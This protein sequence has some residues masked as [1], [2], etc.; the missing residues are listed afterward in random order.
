[1]YQ[2][3][4]TKEELKGRRE[5]LREGIGDATAIIVGAGETSRNEAFQQYHDFYYLC[6][7]ET[8]QSYLAIDGKTGETTLFLPEAALLS[9]D[10]DDPLICVDDPAYAIEVTGVDHVKS[11]AD[12]KEYLAGVGRLYTDFKD[13]EGH[14]TT[15]RSITG[16][17]K[18]IGADPWDGRIDRGAHFIQTVRSQVGEMEIL[19]VSEII[20]LM[21]MDKSL[22]EIEL[23][24]RAGQLTA[25]GLCD[26]MQATQ[27][28]VMEYQLGAILQY[29]Y[30]AGGALGT[31][32]PPIVG[33]G[34]NAYHGHYSVNHSALNDGD[35]VLVDCGPNYHYYTSDITRMWPVNGTYTPAQRALYGFVTEYHKTLISL[36]KP[37]KICDDIEDEAVE[38]MQGRL[39]EFDF[40]TE[41]H[42]TGPQWMF[43]FRQHLAHSVGMSVHDGL[44]HKEA[45]LRVGQV[46]SV[47]PQMKIEA[48]RLYLRVEDTGV[49]T[50]EG[51]DILTK[52]VP[53]ELDAIEAMMKGNGMLQAFPPLAAS[54]HAPSLA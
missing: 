49:V 13:G 53:I 52:D 23:L 6:G 21:R 1:M 2:T 29:H 22:C 20:Y 42:A 35:M 8:P 12:M 45:P 4:F 46:F 30:L 43:D 26:A 32:Y 41:S 27:P 15:F 54:G 10:S 31:G 37:G 50:E 51:F 17:A 33:G 34:V 48:D 25:L 24:R 36:I 3:D 19:D 14:N 28:G 18:G 40:A 11:R 47:D 39:G 44:S 16:A 9:K 38:I 5:K 7:V